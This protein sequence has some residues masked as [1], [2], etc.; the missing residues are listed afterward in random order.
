MRLLVDGVPLVTRILVGPISFPFIWLTIFLYKI[1]DALNIGILN[2]FTLIQYAYLIDFG[3]IESI[4]DVVVLS[5]WLV[6]SV[7]HV[8]AVVGGLFLE[9]YLTGRTLVTRGRKQDRVLI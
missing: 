2:C 8:V 4:A 5:A 7:L 1:C 9:N 3:L 6:V